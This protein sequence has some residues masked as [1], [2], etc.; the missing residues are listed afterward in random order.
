MKEHG[1]RW[2][3]CGWRYRLDT[4][5]IDIKVN[6]IQIC[7]NFLC[8]VMF[9]RTTTFK[10]LVGIDGGVEVRNGETSVLWIKQ[11]PIGNICIRER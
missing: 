8:F 2:G 9:C 4:Q 11:R 7:F 1:V 10:G 3:V 6:A 5:W